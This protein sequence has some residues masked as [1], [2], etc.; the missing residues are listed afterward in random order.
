MRRSLRGRDGTGS[1]IYLQKIVNL[2][3]CYAAI[4]RIVWNLSYKQMEVL[5]LIL[6]IN[7]RYSVRRARD[8]TVIGFI[9]TCALSDYHH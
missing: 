3:E 9:A 6:D 5:P 1:V 2:D 8:R 7:P 4:I